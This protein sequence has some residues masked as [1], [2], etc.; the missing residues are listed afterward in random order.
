MNA[1][2][3]LQDFTTCFEEVQVWEACLYQLRMI[4]EE[5]NVN[6]GSSLDLITAKT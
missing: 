1:E 6:L 5:E 2:H 3:S 4:M